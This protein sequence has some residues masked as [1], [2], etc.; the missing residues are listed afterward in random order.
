MAVSVSCHIAAVAYV[1]FAMREKKRES[2]AK[3]SDIFSFSSFKEGFSV[4]LR[5]REESGMRGVVVATVVICCFCQFAWGV[6]WTFLVF[7][8]KSVLCNLNFATFPR[9]NNKVF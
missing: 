1:V 5:K 2:E 7:V 9:H 4:V 3:I 6:R 8:E